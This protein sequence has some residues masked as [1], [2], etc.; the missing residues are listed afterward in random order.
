MALVEV[1]TLTDNFK[2]DLSAEAVTVHRISDVYVEVQR[3]PFGRPQERNVRLRKKMY[4]V[5]LFSSRSVEWTAGLSNGICVP[6]N[7]D[8][9]AAIIWSFAFAL[10]FECKSEWRK[11]E[12]VV[13]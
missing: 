11:L 8:D 2:L 7:S 13:F 9:G 4:F 5:R 10:Q 6:Q 1:E 12:S 3:R